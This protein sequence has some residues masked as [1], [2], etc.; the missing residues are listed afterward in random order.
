MSKHAAGWQ[1]RLLR[2]YLPWLMLAAGLVGLVLL[3]SRQRQIHQQPMQPEQ[4]GGLVAQQ[5]CTVS[6]VLDQSSDSLRSAE[7]A[8]T[9]IV[10][11][12]ASPAARPLLTGR[13]FVERISSDSTRLPLSLPVRMTP[14]D[15]ISPIAPLEPI[16]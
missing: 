5:P 14:L 1:R 3:V 13:R 16:R 11:T 9:V 10:Q 12:G 2:L 8:G 15:T 7:A 4:V 6:A